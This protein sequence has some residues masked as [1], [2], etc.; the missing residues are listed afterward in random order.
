[1]VIEISSEYIRQLFIN[2]LPFLP[3]ILL[4]AGALIGIFASL[5]LFQDCRELEEDKTYKLGITLGLT[6]FT[7]TGFMSEWLNT[8]VKTLFLT[9]FVFIAGFLGGLGN[10]LLAALLALTGRVLFVGV[11][12][13]IFNAADL[14]IIAICSSLLQYYFNKT[15][16]NYMSLRAGVELILWRFVIVEI[17]LVII[18]FLAP[19]MQDVTLNIMVRRVIGGFSFSVFVVFA[20]IMLLRREQARINQMYYDALT[21]LPNRRSFQKEIEKGYRADPKKRRSLL[22][23]DIKNFRDLLQEMGHDWVDGFCLQLSK[24]LSGLTEKDWLAQY[25]PVVYSFSDHSFVLILHGIWMYQIEDKDIGYRIYNTLL[26]KIYEQGDSIRPWLTISVFNIT[27]KHIRNA[28]HFLQTLTLAERRH[29][30]AVQYFKPDI[31]EQIQ[32]EAYTRHLIEE[33]IC[34]KR[35]PLWLQPKVSLKDGGCVG[36]EALLRAKDHSK[37]LRYLSPPEVFSIAATHRMLEALEWATAET[38]VAYL[39]EMPAELDAIPLSLNLS[40]VTFSQP[41]FGEKLCSLLAEKKIEGHRLVIEIIETSE[42][43]PNAA[44]V[45]ENVSILNKSGVKLSLDDFGTGY[46]SISLLARLDFSELKLD[47]SMISN[48]EDARVWEAIILSVEGA[49]RYSAKVVAEG[50]ESVEQQQQLLAIGVEKGQGFLFGK[51]MEFDDFIHYARQHP[52][53]VERNEQ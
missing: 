18:F 42:I 5:L 28:R 20:V 29:E 15:K 26:Q 43:H 25:R 47:Y 49:K 9:D 40:P 11:E 19:H 24:E 53:H 35:V 51:A 2:S 46:A 21:G 4:Q 52:L 6:S 3:S 45:R 48:M 38:I 27:P 7:L 22:F 17:P 39:E 31:M 10:A 50:I 1:M 13:S 41:G 23:I 32:G 8:P 44:T 30:G 33:W 16:K 34:A 12:N 14:F 37:S 36:A